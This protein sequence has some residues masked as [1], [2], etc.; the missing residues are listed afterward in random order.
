MVTQATILPALIRDTKEVIN[1]Y[2]KEMPDFAASIIGTTE[3]ETHAY[4]EKAAYSGIG[5]ATRRQ[6]G[7]GIQV[8]T[9]SITHTKKYPFVIFTQAVQVGMQTWLR[10]PMGSIKPFTPELARS[11]YNARQQF[12]A[13]ILNNGTD[14]TNYPTIYGVAFFSASQPTVSTTWS[15][16]STAATLSYDSLEQMCIDMDG[17]QTYRDQVRTYP[18]NKRLIVPRQL[19]L[20]AERI[21]QSSLVAGDADNDKNVLRTNGVISEIAWNPFLSS[22]TAY[23]LF[24]I[25]DNP[26]FELTFGGDRIVTSD[27]KGE[28][29]TDSFIMAIHRELGSGV[30]GAWGTQ[31]NAGA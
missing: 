19:R 25:K 31:R 2:H 3:P 12:I 11:M 4:A 23:Y 28:I 21:F 20:R 26:V 22:S 24:D 27:P 5:T 16:I 8:D 14:A 7:Q 15:N 1:G 13:D 10:N 17:H 9:P 29:E 6:E 18:G 30:N